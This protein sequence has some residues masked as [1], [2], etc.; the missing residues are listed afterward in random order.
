MKERKRKRKG[1]EGARVSGKSCLQN[2]YPCTALFV[3]CKGSMII[4]FVRED[5]ERENK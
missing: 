2:F 1:E 4:Y 3:V 5:G